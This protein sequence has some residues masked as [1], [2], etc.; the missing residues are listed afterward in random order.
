MRALFVALASLVPSAAAGPIPTAKPQEVGLDPRRLEVLDAYFHDLV[1]PKRGVQQLAGSTVA[2][3]RDGKLA[4]FKVDGEQVL[5]KVPMGEDTIFRFYSMTK[6]VTAVTLMTLWEEAKFR[7]DDPVSKYLPVFK[8]MRVL[9]TPSSTVDDTV[10]AEGPITV[11]H[12]LTH[13]SGLSYGWEQNAV[14]RFYREQ[15]VTMAGVSLTD[16]VNRLAKAPLL[17]QPGKHWHYS[18]AL[19]VCGAL[20]ESLTGDSFQSV[21]QKRVLDPLGMVDSGFEVAA[22]KRARVS[23]NYLPPTDNTPLLD[24]HDPTCLTAL[25]GASGGG[26]LCGTT[27]DYLRFAMMLANHGEFQGARVLAPRT[28]RLLTANN[29]EGGKDLKTLGTFPGDTWSWNKGGFSGGV[30]DVSQWGGVGQALGGQMIIDPVQSGLA[31][32]K[33]MY[34]WGGAAGTLFHVDFEERMAVV[35]MQQRTDGG[36]S[37]SAGDLKTLAQ[38]AIVDTPK[39]ERWEI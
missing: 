14:D 5:G 8:D 37:R 28:V 24:A 31:T 23:P 12:L 30:G 18:F 22:D 20:V 1:Q 7:L 21:M 35:Y 16:F 4:H 2:I 17:F 25:V 33:G 38:A 9:R 13:T 10:P 15:N 29:V 27:S 39:E 26:G 32:G 6:P 19:D 36:P 3:A 11:R 34:F